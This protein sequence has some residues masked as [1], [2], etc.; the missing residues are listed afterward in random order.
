MSDSRDSRTTDEPFG[1]RSEANG[2][3]RVPGH[4]LAPGDEIINAH[5]RGDR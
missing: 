3:F 1:I 2:T 5:A 4:S